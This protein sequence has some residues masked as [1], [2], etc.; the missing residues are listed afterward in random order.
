MLIIYWI[1]A[2]ALQMDYVYMLGH[3]A[4]PDDPPVSPAVVIYHTETYCPE[5]VQHR[6]RYR[7][8]ECPKVLHCTSLFVPLAA[9]RGEFQISTKKPPTD[10]KFRFS[11]FLSLRS[12]V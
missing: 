11:I 9:F 2:Y 5:G 6:S 7:R 3:A 4:K 8:K 1:A 12:S 10:M